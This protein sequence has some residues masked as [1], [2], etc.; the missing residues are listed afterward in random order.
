MPACYEMTIGERRKYLGRMMLRY[1]EAEREVRSELLTEMEAV[2]GMHRKSLVRLLGQSALERRPRQ[3]Q[4]SRTYGCQVEDIIR[5]VWESLDYVCAERLTPGLLGT[6]QHLAQFGEVQLTAETQLQLSE[7][8]RAT[9]QRFLSRVSQDLPRLPRR[10]PEQANRL[11]RE[12]PMGRM[13]WEI[14]VPGHFE[15]D[16]V[17]HC[18]GTSAGDYVHTLQ[19]VDVATGW[20]EREAVLGRGQRAMEGGFRHILERLPFP[21]VELHPDNGSEFLNDHLIRFWGEKIVGLQ[22]SRS[23]PFHKNDNRFVEQKNDTLVRAYLGQVRLDT[24]AQCQAANVLYDRMWLYY[25]LFQPVLHLVAKQAVDNRI[26]RKWDEAQTPYRRVLA[27]G[28]LSEGES[29]RLSVLYKQTNPRRLRQE[30]YQAIEKLVKHPEAALELLKRRSV[31]QNQSTEEE[32]GCLGIRGRV[33]GAFPLSPD[34]T[35]AATTPAITLADMSARINETRK[36]T[37]VPGNIII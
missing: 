37:A 14:T 23:R 7:I 28:V 32:G 15:V 6:A 31:A 27:T 1:L 26:K 22:L 4:R 17:H 18:G 36:E 34:T 10:G 25:N 16:L 20:S 8:S 30:I 5:V 9:V 24:P 12:I 33:R 3:R 19:L 2:T 29:A 11:A 35:A 13:P 21:I